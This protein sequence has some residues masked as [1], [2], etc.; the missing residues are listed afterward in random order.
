[1]ALCGAVLLG[2]AVL[3]WGLVTVTAPDSP[4]PDA[5]ADAQAEGEEDDGGEVG[6]TLCWTVEILEVLA[7]SSVFETDFREQVSDQVAEELLD[8]SESATDANERVALEVLADHYAAQ[9]VDTA[10]SPTAAG[11]PDLPLLD[12]RP[13]ADVLDAAE[14]LDKHLT[15]C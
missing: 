14:V 9:E 10:T 2:A 4:D 3:V 6:P 5:I 13:S 8:A 11:S 12:S 15:E 7:S 1:M